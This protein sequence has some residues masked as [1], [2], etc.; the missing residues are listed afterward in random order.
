VATVV[1]SFLRAEKSCCINRSEMPQLNQTILHLWRKTYIQR[2]RGRSSD[3][4]LP[5]L[6]AGNKGSSPGGR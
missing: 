6:S 5:S 3:I 4:Q 1:Q 2:W